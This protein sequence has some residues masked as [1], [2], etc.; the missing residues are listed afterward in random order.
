MKKY[1]GAAKVRK[2]IA[3]YGCYF[4]LFLKKREN[5]RVCFKWSAR[6]DVGEID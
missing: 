6:E 2:K 1:K 5:E 4:A 3:Q